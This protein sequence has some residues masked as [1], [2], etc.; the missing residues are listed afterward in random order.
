LYLV[1]M[2]EDPDNDKLGEEFDFI[3]HELENSR[4]GTFYSE[5]LET[6]YSVFAG[7]A[8]REE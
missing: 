8:F 5:Q 7:A 6:A 3:L 4:E 1:D 2:L